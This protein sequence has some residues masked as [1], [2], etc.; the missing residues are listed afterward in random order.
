MI[1]PRQRRHLRRLAVASVAFAAL[2]PSGG[3]ASTQPADSQS[4]AA[5]APQPVTNASPPVVVCGQT[6]TR[7]AAGPSIT[8]FTQPGS[9]ELH[10][11]VTAQPKVIP[12]PT[13]LQFTASCQTGVSVAVQP[14]RFL[15]ILNVAH[16]EDHRVAAI[17]LAGERVG[18]ARVIVTRANGQK[19]IIMIHVNPPAPYDHGNVVET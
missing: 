12:F 15:N 9:Y 18:L 10:G 5:E 1:A 7:S 16:T 17:A 8:D 6:L 11:G 19:T 13:L 3:S 4:V 14:Y 2:P